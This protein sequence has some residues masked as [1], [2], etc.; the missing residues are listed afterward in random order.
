MS[1]THLN[2]TGWSDAHRIEARDLAVKAAMLGRRMNLSM[3]YDQGPDRWDGIKHELKAY[4]GEFPRRTD[5]SG[6]VTWCIWNGMSHFDLKHDTV[7][8]TGWSWGWTGTMWDHAARVTNGHLLRA[9]GIL[10]GDPKGRTGHTALYV[11][12][13]KVISFGGEPGPRLLDWDYRP[14]V[15]VFRAI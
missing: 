7:N 15:A 12:G 14:P 5:C 13:G 3:Q 1:R 8:G 11:G 10:Y 9:D 6:F 2:P 4:K